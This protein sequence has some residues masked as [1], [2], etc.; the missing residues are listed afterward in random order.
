VNSTA[1]PQIELEKLYLV[2][3]VRL[4]VFTLA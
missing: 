4:L 3:N 1:L 2:E